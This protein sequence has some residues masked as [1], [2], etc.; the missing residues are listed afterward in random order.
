[1]NPRQ[2]RGSQVDVF[3]TD[4]ASYHDFLRRDMFAPSAKRIQKTPH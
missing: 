4:S 2:F 3:K 1:M